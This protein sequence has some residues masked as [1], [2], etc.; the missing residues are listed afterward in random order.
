MTERR[1]TIRTPSS[2]AVWF[3]GKGYAVA[4]LLPLCSHKHRT[5]EAAVKCAAKLLERAK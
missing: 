3:D 1:A 5:D 4:K 2:Y